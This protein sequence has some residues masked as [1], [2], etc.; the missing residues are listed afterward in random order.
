MVLAYLDVET[1]SPNKEPMLSDKV[2][3]IYYKEV[4]GGNEEVMFKEWSESEEMI[5]KNFYAMLTKKLSAEKTLTLIGW[6]IIR[7]DIPFLA[8][9]LFFHRIESLDNILEN[10]R[11]AYLRDLRQCLLPFNK[12]SFDGLSE[13]EV[14]RRFR[15]EPPKYSNK[16]IKAFYEKGEYKKIEEHALSEMKFF[17]NL[18]WKMRDLGEIIKVFAQ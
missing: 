1:Y 13:K 12:Y 2:I 5:L 16:D 4:C 3:L 15:I 7:F 9:R 18:A 6:N 8:Y 11:K 17:S 10:F 14:A